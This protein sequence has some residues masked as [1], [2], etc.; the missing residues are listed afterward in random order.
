MKDLTF[1]DQCKLATQ[2]GFNAGS[3]SMLPSTN[4]HKDHSRLHIFWYMGYTD[5]MELLAETLDTSFEKI[6]EDII[7]RE[8]MGL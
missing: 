5:A 7:W 1:E 8:T 6:Y 3:N 4:P 2:S